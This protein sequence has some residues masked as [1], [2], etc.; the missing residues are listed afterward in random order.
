MN[1]KT[2]ALPLAWFT[3]ATVAALVAAFASAPAARGQTFLYWDLNGFSAGS[4]GA[5]GNAPSGTW[6]DAGVNWTTAADGSGAPFLW[7]DNAVAVFSAGTNATGSYTVSLGAGSSLSASGI[8]FQDGTVTLGGTGTLSFSQPLPGIAP[9]VNLGANPVTI[10]SGVT[11]SSLFGLTFGG[12][13]GNVTLLGTTNVL[14][15]TT[16]DGL[17]L[18]LGA[19]HRLSDASTV[20]VNADGTLNLAGFNETVGG[21]AGSGTVLLGAG[22][23]TVASVSDTTFSGAMTGPGALVKSGSATLA[24]GSAVGWTG[25]TTINAGVLALGASNIFPDTASLVVNAGGTFSLGTFSDRLAAVTGSGTVTLG[26]G[27][28]ELGDASSFAFDGVINGLG[29]LVKRGAGTL[30]LGGANTFLGSASITAGTLHLGANHRLADALDVDVAAGATLDLSGHQEVIDALTGTGTV[31]L[32]GAQLGAGWNN[33]T[34][35]VGA[36]LTGP[37]DFNKWGNGIVTLNGTF[38]PSGT[39]GVQ[40]GILGLGSPDRLADGTTLFVAPGA[41]FTLNNHTETVAALTGLGTVALGTGRLTVA[42]PGDASF[43]GAIAGGGGGITKNGP[44]TF[45]LLGVSTYTGT[46]QVNAGVLRLVGDNRLPYG[47]NAAVAAGATLELAAVGFDGGSQTFGKITGAGDVANTPD[48]YLLTCALGSDNS[49]FTF[50][51]RLRGITTYRKLGSGTLTLTGASDFTNDFELLFGAVRIAADQRLPQNHTANYL[52]SPGTTLNLDGHVQKINGLAGLGTLELGT[53]GVANLH[54]SVGTAT[55][56]FAGPVT[57]LGELSKTG[58]LRFRLAGPLLFSG[59]T[60]VHAGQLRLAR[61]GTIDTDVVVDAGAAFELEDVEVTVRQLTGA[62]GVSLGTGQLV[63]GSGGGDFAFGGALTGGGGS[64]FVKNGAGVLTLNGT[65]TPSTLLINGSKLVL[66]ANERVG[67]TTAVQVVPGAT[68]DVA[69]RTETIG[70]LTGD[71]AVTLGAGSLAVGNGG[72]GFAFGGSVNGAGSLTKVGGGTFTLTG[73]LLQTGGLGVSAGALQLG[74]S[75][76]ILDTTT[77][78]L[79][80]GA[81]FDLGGR[82]ETLAAITGPGAVKLPS[83]SQLTLGASD[84]TSTLAAKLNGDGALVKTGAGDVTFTGSSNGELSVSIDQGRFHLGGD[85]LFDPQTHVAAEGTGIF[86]VSGFRQEV[87]ILSGNGIARVVG[88][89]R[90]LVNGGN[91]L[92]TLDNLGTVEKV[93]PGAFTLEQLQ[94]SIGYVVISEGSLNLAAEGAWTFGRTTVEPHGTLNLVGNSTLHG[95]LIHGGTL[96]GVTTTLAGTVTGAGTFAG[97]IVLADRYAPGATAGA[98]TVGAFGSALTLAP[99]H[100]LELDL[101]GLTRGTQHD[102]LDVAGPLTLGGTLRVVLGGGFVPAAGHTFQLFAAGSRSGDF[103][104]YDLPALPRGLAWNTSRLRTAGELSVLSGYAAFVAAAG[105]DPATD[106]APLAN[107]SG[108]GVANLLKYLLGGDPRVAQRDLLPLATTDVGAGGTVLVLSYD[109]DA[110]AAATLSVV[111][112]DYSTD[113]ATWTPVV[114]GVGGATI[115]V[116]PVDAIFEHVEVRIPIPGNK[117]FAR[118]RVT[119]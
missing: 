29:S 102:A 111:G 98:T 38:G 34:F 14:G 63:V 30:T 55:Y 86:N 59:P 12:N 58:G 114:H 105:L 91:F 84:T 75:E 112:A 3:A 25:G 26:A 92:G 65:A 116:T 74:G 107:P 35:T 64:R 32:T 87:K 82:D 53:N 28:L 99:T 66:G 20:Q 76:R 68:F 49:S 51:G 36:T 108:D 18:Q 77:L 27:T 15:T 46:T 117:G 52:L 23:L 11:L 45:T 56:D 119:L 19:A 100:T 94:N 72:A 60:A 101:K 7:I 104:A 93:G 54:A 61:S 37:G 109:R 33:G 106:G 70:A 5:G 40:Q 80:T 47:A 85:N 97:D 39:F 13:G 110:L 90:L 24:L 96:S 4:G 103:T 41:T 31:L 8:L 44:G 81:I 50:D 88:F 89:G 83:G 10:G 1:S 78:A 71:G 9:Y 62:G 79:A 113:L 43:S 95:E 42:G 57:G 21:L 6:S 16:L 22:T 118:L 115:S 17:V 69:G 73:Q 48:N 67:D 2:R